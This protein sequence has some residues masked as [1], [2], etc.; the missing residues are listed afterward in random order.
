M[1][2]DSKD[3]LIYPELPEGWEADISEDEDEIVVRFP[4]GGGVVVGKHCE[5]LASIA[6]YEL[7]RD[8]FEERR[9]RIK[10]S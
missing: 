1:S 4:E 5:S 2:N 8:M 9:N 3:T 6:L 7:I 10:E